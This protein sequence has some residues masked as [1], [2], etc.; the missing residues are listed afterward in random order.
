MTVST[1][2]KGITLPKHDRKHNLLRKIYPK[3]D[4]YSYSLIG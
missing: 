1:K 3:E 2:G 4:I